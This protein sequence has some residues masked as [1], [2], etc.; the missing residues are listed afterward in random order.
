LADGFDRAHFAAR[1]GAR[2]LGHALLVRERTVSTNDDAWEAFGSLGD[3]ASVIALEQSRGRGREGR[4][5]ESAP[6]LG[7]ALSVALR[8]GCDVRQAG[9]VPLA[10]GLAVLQAVH[11]LGVGAARL[12]WPNDVVVGSRKLAGVLCE[13][14]RTPDQTE[15]VVIGMGLN[16]RQRREDFAGALAETAT[17]L[18][19]EGSKATLE[20]AAAE[21]LTRLEPVWA[22]SQEGDRAAVLAAWSRGCDHWGRRL[23]VRTPSGAVEGQALRLDPDGGLVL[24]MDDGRETTVVAGDVVPVSEGRGAA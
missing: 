19:L 2:R 6:G 5:W 16:V 20:D 10:A 18:A 23:S 4:R 11:A 12:K 1:L 13:L 9:I 21:I 17:S 15:V 22:E 3:G 7:L 14:K 8:L 24:R